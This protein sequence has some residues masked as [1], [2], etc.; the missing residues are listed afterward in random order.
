MFMSVDASVH[1]FSFTIKN[2]LAAKLI[3]RALLAINIPRENKNEGL[4][5]VVPFKKSFASIFT[6]INTK[7]F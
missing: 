1:L 4:Y 2:G 3:S 6:D 5:L 7:H